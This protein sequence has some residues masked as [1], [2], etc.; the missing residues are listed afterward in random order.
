MGGTLYF[1]A[2]A[3]WVA[4]Q[5]MKTGDQT[6]IFGQCKCGFILEILVK[7]LTLQLRGV[8]KLLA[9]IQKERKCLVIYLHGPFHCPIPQADVIWT[10]LKIKSLFLSW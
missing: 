9:G 8:I 7:C 2:L 3:P 5:Q 10:Q 6:I 1:V 4:H